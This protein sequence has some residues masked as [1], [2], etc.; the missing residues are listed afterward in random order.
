MLAALASA[1]I[2]G[3]LSVVF[4]IVLFALKYAVAQRDKEVD[5]RLDAGEKLSAAN[6]EELKGQAERMRNQELKSN[7]LEGD[8]KLTN[9]AH[10]TADNDIDDIKKSM[11]TRQEFDRGMT[12]IEGML[13]QNS[14]LLSQIL[15]QLQP[16][17]YASQQ[18]FPAQPSD[19]SS[20]DKDRR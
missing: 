14:T 19:P 5:R 1:I 9:Q 18:R 15:S 16:P 12:S 7:T 4:G 20:G 3:I 6:A 17:R 8:L 13:R 10:T 2:S 11:I